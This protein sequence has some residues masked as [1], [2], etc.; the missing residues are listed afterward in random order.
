MSPK[1]Y[2]VLS[3][4]ALG[5]YLF[6]LTREQLVATQTRKMAE[7]YGKAVLAAVEKHFVEL[8]DKSV[9]L[10]EDKGYQVVDDSKW[11]AELDKFIQMIIRPKVE[12]FI[13]TPADE[14]VF[15]QFATSMTLQLLEGDVFPRQLPVEKFC[16]DTIRP[17]GEA[18][19]MLLPARWI[20]SLAFFAVAIY[21]AIYQGW[22]ASLL[23]LIAGLVI[24]PLAHQKAAQRAPWY[25]RFNLGLWATL[26]VVL[27]ANFSY[28]QHTRAV[29]EEG[30]AL[31]AEQQKQRAIEQ[32]RIDEQRR[33]EAEQ[34]RRAAEAQ[35][36]SSFTANRLEILDSL[37]LAIEEERFTDAK[38]IIDEYSSVS[39][40][41]LVAL[42]NEYGLKKEAAEAR[43]AAAKAERDRQENY[44][45][46]I[47]D[48]AIDEYTPAQYPRLTSKYR[49]RLTEIEAFRRTAAERVIDSGKCDYVENVQLSDES[50]LQS[51]KF[52]ID[53]ANENRIYLS[54]SDLN[55]GAEVRTQSERGWDE[56]EAIVE[57]RSMVK[58]SATIPSSVNFHSFTGTRATTAATTG[59]VQVL[60]S[61]DAKNAFGTEIGYTA[62]CIFEPRKQGSIE[63]FL[64]E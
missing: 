3:L 58:R 27:L 20:F 34:R 29:Y 9:F 30:R 11:K 60:L 56:G 42:K 32:Q 7:A 8:K 36:A 37:S 59:N 64:R 2:L 35:A 6:W 41:N 1:L 22:L 10:V 23:M 14:A 48:Y 38:A 33:V 51:L 18:A 19:Q 24:N 53:C 57:C 31:L 62:R 55:S 61:F 13:K 45:A 12:G 49:S 4:L 43:E 52:F 54:E 5:A 26:G 15:K 47:R 21:T 17:D 25:D 44:T 46:R 50:S 16:A 28:F 63:I 40:S 39:D